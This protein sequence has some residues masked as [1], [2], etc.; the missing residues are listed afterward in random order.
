M[1]FNQNEFG[2]VGLG[3]VGPILGIEAGAFDRE[4]HGALG[5]MEGERGIGSMEQ[6]GITYM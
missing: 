3:F 6:G 4:E 1:Q 2:F 5:G